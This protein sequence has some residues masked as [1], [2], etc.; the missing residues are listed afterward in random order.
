MPI[1]FSNEDCFG[2]TAKRSCHDDHHRLHHD[3]YIRMIMGLMIM[4]ILVIS[5]RMD[6][7][8]TVERLSTTT[9]RHSFHLILIRKKHLS[10]SQIKYDHKIT[11]FNL[12]SKKNHN[13]HYPI[14]TS[15]PLRCTQSGG[16]PQFLLERLC[17]VFSTPR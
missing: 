1:I 2:S 5:I 13:H 17:W 16:V 14:P 15:S 12:I 7:D 8:L 10:A 4:V 11:I 3:G 9:S 6:T